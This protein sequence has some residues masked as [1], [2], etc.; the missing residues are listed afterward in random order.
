MGYVWLTG[1]TDSSYSGASVTLPP[2]NLVVPAN[3]V[4]KKFMLRN[5]R[6]Q[7][8][9]LTTG[10]NSVGPVSYEILVNITT[11]H[12]APRLI[13]STIYRVPMVLG[14]VYDALTAQRVYDAYYEAG[15]KECGFNQ[16]CDYGKLGYP[17]MNVQLSHSVFNSMPLV[18]SAFQWWITYSFAVLYHI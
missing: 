17:S 16:T 15:D 14:A 4:M 10:A 13:F 11:G 8:R 18:G 5:V 6:I 3:G 9:N 7:G 1:G 12:Y 2:V